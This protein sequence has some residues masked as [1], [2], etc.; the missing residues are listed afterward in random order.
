ME[1]NKDDIKFYFT[2]REA[3][4]SKIVTIINNFVGHKNLVD[5][6]DVR[7][8]LYWECTS[9]VLESIW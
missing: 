6:C 3:L 7:I 1:E 5:T 2:A 8:Q 4:N 9:K